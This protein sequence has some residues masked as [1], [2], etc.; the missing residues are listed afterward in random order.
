MGLNLTKRSGSPYWYIRGSIKGIKI[1]ESTG[2]SHSDKARPSKIAED[3]RDKR[4]HDIEHASVYGRTHSATFLDAAASYLEAGGSPRFLGDFDKLTGN[5]SGLVGK[6]GSKPLKDLNQSDLNGVAAE[7]YPDCRPETVN[8]QFWTPFIAVWNH[9][10]KGNNPLC[11]QVTW[12]RPHVTHKAKPRKGVDYK[13]AIT[14]INACDWHAA[15]IL[16]F[17][18]WTGCRPEE[19]FTLLGDSVN[20]K[21]KWV[22]IETTK[23]DVPRGV[24]LHKA[25]IPL[26]TF[27]KERGGHVFLSHLGKPYASRKKYNKAGRL[28]VQG[29]GQI[30]SAVSTAQQKTGLDIVPYNARHTVSTYLIWPGGV[31]SMIKD[32]ILGHA[33]ASDMSKYYVHLP[34]Q[35]L[36]DAINVLPDPRKLGL[37]EDLWKVCKIRA[38]AENAYVKTK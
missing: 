16:F 2:I 19:A 8:R 26:L 15:K 27:E 12:Q 13:D 25:L 32:E 29:G 9:A 37:R 5:W 35:P 18:F 7:M 24:P 21:Q 33:D 4:A 38:M 20:P 31:N 10:S 6:L 1:F 28:L 34:R 30:K 11:Q 17:L 14:F 23:T 22:A 36:I 3:Y